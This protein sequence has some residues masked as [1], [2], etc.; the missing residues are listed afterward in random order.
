[1]EVTIL[2]VTNQLA[3]IEGLPKSEALAIVNIED[4]GTAPCVTIELLI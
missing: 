4:H 2:V 1:L 3:N